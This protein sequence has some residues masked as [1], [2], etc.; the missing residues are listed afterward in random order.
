M[1]VTGDLYFNGKHVGQATPDPNSTWTTLELRA[2]ADSVVPIV[3]GHNVAPALIAGG[4]GM[5]ALV[6]GYNVAFFDNFNMSA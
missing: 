5:V 3:N 4:N 2:T 6:S 1:D